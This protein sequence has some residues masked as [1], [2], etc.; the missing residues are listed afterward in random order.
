V[1]CMII[2]DEVFLEDVE[3]RDL[4]TGVSRALT[5]GAIVLASKLLS[6]DDM[7]YYH[8]LACRYIGN[9]R[10]SV[11]LDKSLFDQIV[12]SHTRLAWKHALNYTHGLA[13]GH[14]STVIDEDDLFIIAYEALHIAMLR[15]NP[16]AGNHFSTYATWWL[17]QKI[18]RYIDDHI[19]EIRVPVHM[20]TRIRYLRSAR[21]RLFA[22]AERVATDQE[23]F[24]YLKEHD[25]QRLWTP[26]RFREV[27]NAERVA[28]NTVSLDATSEEFES[29]PNSMSW[30]GDPSP[31]WSS[32]ADQTS[33]GADPADGEST[34]LADQQALVALLIES[35]HLSQKE[36]DIVKM[37]YGIGVTAAMSLDEVGKVYNV[38][39]ERIRQVQVGA[40]AKLAKAAKKMKGKV[41]L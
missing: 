18:R 16:D 6:H 37:R 22:A 20:Q 9:Q 3:W 41:V 28:K 34:A 14:Q 39:R 40:M 30:K 4:S 19:D 23:V 7:V 31:F 1:V 27:V 35:A 36:A 12:L 2:R 13:A 24:D 32:M 5:T 38:T 26:K 11:I 17:H 8:K 21:K 25:K 15:W 10:D 33:Y 29:V